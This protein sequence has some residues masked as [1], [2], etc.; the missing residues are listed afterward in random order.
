LIIV[1]L[2]NSKPGDILN[3]YKKPLTMA[4]KIVHAIISGRV[5]GV[6]F[7]D[8]TRK[9]AINI[10]LTG[11]VRNLPDRT[12]EAVISGDS[13]TVDQMIGW[14][15]RGSPGSRVDHVQVDVLDTDKSYSSF[16]VR[17]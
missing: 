11:W 15:H 3:I 14:L 1:C 2:I 10:G 5:Q 13:E 8:Y 9:E 16:E 6:F 4:N 7:R 12:V 17:Y